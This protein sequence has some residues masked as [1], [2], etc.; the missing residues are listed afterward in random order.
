M[1]AKHQ[2]INLTELL[3]KD[4]IDSKSVNIASR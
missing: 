2:K 4:A 1:E 3:N